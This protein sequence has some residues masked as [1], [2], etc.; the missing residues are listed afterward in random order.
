MGEINISLLDNLCPVMPA[1]PLL[2]YFSSRRIVFSE[3]DSWA[4]GGR[5]MGPTG[6]G[7][8]WQIYGKK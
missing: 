1:R 8:E 7:K 4:F 2:L 5:I 6:T 3:Q